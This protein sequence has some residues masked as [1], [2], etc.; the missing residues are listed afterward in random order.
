MILPYVDH[1]LSSCT[2]LLESGDQRIHA[3]TNRTYRDSGSTLQACR[4]EG[5][6]CSERLHLGNLNDLSVASDNHERAN[7]DGKR[8]AEMG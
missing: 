7:V 4:P 2:I 1:M 5:K 3:R 6:A 8:H